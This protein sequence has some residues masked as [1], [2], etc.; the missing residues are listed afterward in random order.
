M[1][2]PSHRF[3]RC[4]PTAVLLLAFLS[5]CF[6]TH[7]AFVRIPVE[8]QATDGGAAATIRLP[9][10][11]LREAIEDFDPERTTYFSRGR[12]PITHEYEDTDGDGAPDFVI[13]EIPTAGTEHWV[14]AVMHR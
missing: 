4:I 14:I 10:T 1:P 5:G 12:Q 9:L 2:H 7:D 8:I 13:V 6:A 3:A 11:K